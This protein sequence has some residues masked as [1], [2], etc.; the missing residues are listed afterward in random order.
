VQLL[1]LRGK[2]LGDGVAALSYEST[3]V[4]SSVLTFYVLYTQLGQSEYG[5]LVGVAGLSGT[6][7]LCLTSWGQPWLLEAVM[8]RGRT[9]ADC[10]HR[11]VRLCVEAALLCTLITV[12]LGLVLVPG[13]RVPVLIFGGLA[14]GLANGVAFALVGVIQLKSTF[15]RATL[16]RTAIALVRPL[17]AGALI[18]IDRLTLQSFVLTMSCLYAVVTGAIWFA[19]RRSLAPEV[20]R[21]PLSVVAREGAPYGVVSF[22]WALQE[23]FDKT[24]L[25]TFGFVKDAA[26]YAAGY[27]F[28]QMATLPIKALVQAS[29]HRFLQVD[30]SPRTHLRRAYFLSTISAIYALVATAGLLVGLHLL[31]RYSGDTFAGAITPARYL[32]GLIIL[33]SVVWYPFN[34]LLAFALARRRMLILVG[35]SILNLG[36]NLAFI[37]HF[38]WKA[39]V[40]STY[41]TEV[42]FAAACWISLIKAVHV[43]EK[44]HRD[45]QS[46]LADTDREN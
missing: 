30:D 13:A 32:A 12:S 42:A 20:N 14:D 6:T 41:V 26:T 11:V 44:S 36:L 2:K 39:A 34:G 18:A 17:S 10:A 3:V 38:S 37:P 25:N 22:T 8:K 15:V 5:V 16:T 4:L 45:Q 35:T 28:V 40:W 46:Q 19:V 33:R 43:S 29:H 7:T 1:T 31:E 24:L 9:L 27:K 23:D 21:L